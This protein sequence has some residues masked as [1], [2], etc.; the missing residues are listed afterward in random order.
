M[1]FKIIWSYISNTAIANIFTQK[2]TPYIF[3]NTTDKIKN[4]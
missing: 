4:R 3:I 1:S 2:M